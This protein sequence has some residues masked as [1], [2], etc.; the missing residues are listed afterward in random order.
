MDFSLLSA[1]CCSYGEWD[2]S[3]S[4]LVFSILAHISFWMSGGAITDSKYRSS[5]LVGFRHPVTALHA[6]S[7]AYS[8]SGREV[9]SPRL[10][11][12]L[13]PQSSLMPM[14]LF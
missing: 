6:L 8:V 3:V 4:C 11:P 14:M 13:L 7:C 10:V 12:R 5:T 2:S 9:I 1:W